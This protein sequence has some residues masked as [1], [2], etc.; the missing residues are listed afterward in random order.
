MVPCGTSECE[1]NSSHPHKTIPY[2]MSKT[3][4]VLGATGNQGSGV[5]RALLAQPNT[6]H[7]RAITRST[8]SA[9]AQALQAKYKDD[10]RFHLVEADMYDTQTLLDAFRGVYGVF[11]VTNNRLPG[12]KIEAEGDLRHELEAGWNVVAAAK[13]CGV[14]HLVLSSLP[15][16]TLAS[17]GRFQKVF[18]FDHKAQI[19]EWARS[20]LP[21]AVTALHPGLFYT[22]FNWDQYY[23]VAEDG[24]VR[25]CAPVNGEKR[26]DWVDP[27]FDI[28]VYAARIFHL[29]P[30]KTG[31]K[32]YPVVGPKYSFADMARIFQEIT[33]REAFFSPSTLDEWGAVVAETVG[34]GY[35]EDI[36][37]MMQWIAVAPDGKVCY[38]TM[39]P[40][41]DR[42]WEELGVRA[43]SFEEWIG[44]GWLGPSRN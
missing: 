17:E 34:K 26:A 27:A 20:Q 35:E 23:R 3:I 38:G 24:R 8:T 7:V 33:S 43:S 44:R 41:E 22:N 6:F 19:E 31:S 16:I 4:A 37:Q 30:E 18:H 40:G 9:P 29:G 10:V 11:A 32:I 42:S 5:I 21:G 14:K 36:R 13:T 25:F 2:T 28:G 39:D 1:N 15:N 12:R